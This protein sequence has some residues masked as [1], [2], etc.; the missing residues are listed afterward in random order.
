MV[1]GA[2]SGKR[3]GES[4]RRQALRC[5]V[6]A[7]GAGR[8]D[9]QGARFSGGGGYKR[10]RGGTGFRLAAGELAPWTPALGALFIRDGFPCDGDGQL[11]VGAQQVLV[12]DVLHGVQCQCQQ[13]VAM[14]PVAPRTLLLA[15][16]VVGVGGA[17]AVESG[18]AHGAAALGGGGQGEGQRLLGVGY[19][20]QQGQQCGC[21]RRD[22]DSAGAA[23]FGDWQCEPV[24]G[25]C[26]GAGNAVRQAAV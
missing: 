3:Q 26:G 1:V 15:G 11:A 6:A 18:I 22:A 4:T 19:G 12:G 14:Q 5:R 23:P 16:A 13:I 21:A 8:A 2:L 24:Y 9:G 17:A 7:V 20:M 10:T 25:Q